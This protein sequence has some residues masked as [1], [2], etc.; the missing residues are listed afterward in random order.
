M[1]LKKNRL[2]MENLNNDENIMPKEVIKGKLYD[3]VHDI[4]IKII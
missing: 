1:K 3:S 2:K 4:H